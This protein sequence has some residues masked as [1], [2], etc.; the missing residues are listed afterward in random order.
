MCRSGYSSF[1]KLLSTEGV[2]LLIF[3]AGLWD[4]LTEILKQQGPVSDNV[5]IVS[6][7]LVFEEGGVAVDYQKP[8]IHS[9]K[10][11]S[12]PDHFEDV[13]ESIKVSS[14]LKMDYKYFLI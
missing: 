11:G 8:V 2:P 4:S 13:K 10:K 5:H 12:I 14:E 6:N 3:S 9:Y 1:S 7:R